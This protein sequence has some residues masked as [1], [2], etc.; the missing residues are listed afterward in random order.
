VNLCRQVII[1]ADPP[2]LQ[3]DPVVLDEE[4]VRLE[5][6]FGDRR[7]EPALSLLERGLVDPIFYILDVIVDDRLDL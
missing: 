6:L 4:R 3:G 7:A 1:E 5:E 2:L